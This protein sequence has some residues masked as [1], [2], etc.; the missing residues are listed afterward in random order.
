M[1]RKI[2]R[3]VSGGLSR[4]VGFAGNYFRKL[5][6]GLNGRSGGNQPNTSV[7]E[8]EEKYRAI[9]EN[10]HDVYYRTDID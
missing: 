1:Q 10:V 2:A 9:F 8:N 7:S 6:P 5:L 4:T 3:I